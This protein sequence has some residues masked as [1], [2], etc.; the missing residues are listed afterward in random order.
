MAA[1]QL[2]CPL[3][4]DRT[5][6]DGATA[7]TSS[8]SLASEALATGSRTARALVPMRRR[9]SAS[10]GGARARGEDHQSAASRAGRIEGPLDGAAPV[11]LS[12][13]TTTVASDPPRLAAESFLTV[14]RE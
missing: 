5:V 13:M 9:F 7:L 12:D 8:K 4:H 2:L 14:L 6:A 11:R 10:S 1:P 3:A